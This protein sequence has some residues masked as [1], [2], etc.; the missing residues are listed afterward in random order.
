MI[1]LTRKILVWFTNA[2]VTSNKLS[3]VEPQGNKR[4]M[5]NLGGI[6]TYNNS[7]EFFKAVK[8]NSSY[9][10][11]FYSVGLGY[12]H[13]DPGYHTYGGYY[14]NNDL[15]NITVN[16]SVRFFENKITLSGNVG[17]QR[18]NLDD[19]K[20]SELKRWVSAINLGYS[21]TEKLNLSLA[22]SNFQSYTHIRS[23]FVDINQLTPYDNL[24]TLDFTQL[25]R[26]A[27]A[28]VN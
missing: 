27:S 15:E 17:K 4:P 8:M 7:T 13:I 25:S 28:N 1:P 19:K 12:E 11:S 21:P 3:A 9:N 10:G 22:F 2:G 24:D 16:G 6:Y 14:F 5:A 23:Q 26:N 20:L 18:D